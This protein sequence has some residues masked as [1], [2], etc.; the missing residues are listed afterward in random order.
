MTEIFVVKLHTSRGSG[1]SAIFSTLE[2]AERLVL[3]LGS[4]LSF[5]EEHSAHP[6]RPHEL[7]YIDSETN[8]SFF[9]SRLTLHTS[10]EI[11]KKILH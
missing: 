5:I 11:K 10:V 1:G 8:E 6:S 4:Q 7:R 9:F 3:R 2:D